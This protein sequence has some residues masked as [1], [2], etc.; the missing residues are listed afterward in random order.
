MIDVARQFET[1]QKLIQSQDQSLGRSLE[2]G[3]LG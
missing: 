3:R 1:G 2:V